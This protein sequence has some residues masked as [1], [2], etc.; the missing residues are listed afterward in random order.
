M[1][2]WCCFSEHSHNITQES[3]VIFSVF[4]NKIEWPWSYQTE[5]RWRCLPDLLDLRIFAFSLCLLLSP[6][7]TLL[8]PYSWP[9]SLIFPLHPLPNL[10]FSPAV[11]QCMLNHFSCV[12]LFENVWT[13]I[14]QTC[15]SMGF[16]RKE[17]WSGLPCPSPGDLLDL[18]TEPTSPMSPALRAGSL[19]LAPQDKHPGPVT[20]H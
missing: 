6:S 5:Q 1:L 18:G 10:L 12:Q 17:Y 9:V 15:L 8:C 13:V 19:P 20:L 3:E 4:R 2:S 11:H 16:S 7:S 14:C